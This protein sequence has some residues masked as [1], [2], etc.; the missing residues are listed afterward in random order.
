MNIGFNG[1]LFGSQQLRLLGVV[2]CLMLAG[3][4]FSQKF[5]VSEPVRDPASVTWRTATDL[6]STLIGEMTKTDVALTNPD[7]PEADRILFTAYRRLLTDIMSSGHPNAGEALNKAY[8]KILEESLTNPLL[9]GLDQNGFAALAE[10]LIELL[11]PVPV[12]EPA[13]F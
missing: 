11:Q 10:G 3:T 13:R 12:D 4:T 8:T 5:A 6:S 2:A 1:N 7:L 9:K